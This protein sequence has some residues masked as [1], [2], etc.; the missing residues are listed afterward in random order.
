MPYLQITPTYPV[1]PIYPCYD[2]E[3]ESTVLFRDG[4]LF[5]R[6]VILGFGVFVFRF[7]V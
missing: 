1:Y 6:Y 3:P 4:R 2:P 7:R 5:G